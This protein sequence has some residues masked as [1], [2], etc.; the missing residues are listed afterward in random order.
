[1]TDSL[2]DS[3]I[4]RIYSRLQKDVNISE[5]KTKQELLTKVRNYP[6]TKYWNRRLNDFFWDI[7]KLKES[8]LESVPQIQTIPAK[9]ISS[10]TPEQKKRRTREIKT[11]TLSIKGSRRQ[12]PYTRRIGRRW[13]DEEINFAKRL[14]NDGLTYL[15]IAN[16]I[17][18]TKSSVSTKLNRIKK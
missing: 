14:K 9:P 2:T 11:L 16:Q 5:I 18:R 13:K 1:M 12:K 4:D 17:E 3:D 8:V 15:Q 6:N 7:H 10:L